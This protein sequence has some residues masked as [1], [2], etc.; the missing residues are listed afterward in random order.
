MPTAPCIIRTVAQHSRLVLQIIENIHRNELHPVEEA[1]AFKRLMDE[2]NLTHPDLAGRVG[3][4]V[5]AIN[6]TLPVPDLRP[7]LL[8]GIHASDHA[9]KSVLLEIAK[10]PDPRRQQI[11]WRQ[12]QT[13]GLTVRT[14]RAVKRD[15]SPQK[16]ATAETTIELPEATVA[17]KFRFGE[18][19]DDRVC[20]VLELALSSRRGHG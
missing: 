20:E 3:E 7:D 4:S 8:A 2:F 6:Q 9:T 18:A 12:A 14:A 15:G 17:V 13:G 1:R 16:R 19:T 11:L 10:E 5:A